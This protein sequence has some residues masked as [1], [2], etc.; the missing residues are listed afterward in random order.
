M[1]FKCDI[2]PKYHSCRTTRE[3]VTCTTDLYWTSPNIVQKPRV[4]CRNFVPCDGTPCRRQWFIEVRRRRVGEILKKNFKRKFKYYI[5]FRILLEKDHITDKEESLLGL[6][7]K[8]SIK[9]TLDVT[10]L[11]TWSPI[12]GSWRPKFPK[13]DI[14]HDIF[15]LGPVDTD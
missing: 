1:V 2:R 11:A 10:C 7:K 12:D 13:W 14:L 9:V 6:L 8:L 5:T 15:G 4:I 3:F